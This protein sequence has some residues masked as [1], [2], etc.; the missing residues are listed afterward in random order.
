[1]ALRG[2]RIA[3]V[4]KK[5]DPLAAKAREMAR[6]TSGARDVIASD[7][8]V[9]LVGQLRA[10]DDKPALLLGQTVE[11]AVKRALPEKDHAV[12]P[13]GRHENREILIRGGRDMADEKIAVAFPRRLREAGEKIQKERIAQHEIPALRARHDDSDRRLSADRTRG[14]V[15]PEGIILFPGQLPDALL[16]LTIN[17]RTVVERAR[18]GRNGDPRKSRHILQCRRASGHAL[19]HKSSRSTGLLMHRLQLLASRHP[20]PGAPS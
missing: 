15:V 8:A 20:S 10:P 16:G 18:G 14:H 7:R 17:G 3:D 4:S 12:G 2:L 6:R 9:I 13:R 19:S 11:G 5:H 1:M